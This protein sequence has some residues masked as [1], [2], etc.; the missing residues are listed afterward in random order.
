MKWS[1]I[2]SNSKSYNLT[3]CTCGLLEIIISLAQR[4]YKA[5]SVSEH[6]PKSS[7]SHLPVSQAD[8]ELSFH[9]AT[10]ALDLRGKISK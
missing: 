5:G 10:L 3:Y 2:K 9:C 6:H 7:D 4:E 1:E 8:W